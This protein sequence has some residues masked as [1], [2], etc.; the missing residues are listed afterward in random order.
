MYLPGTVPVTW[1]GKGWGIEVFRGDTGI[2]WL[3]LFCDRQFVMA[4]IWNFN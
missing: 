4:W 3:L 2:V 1:C